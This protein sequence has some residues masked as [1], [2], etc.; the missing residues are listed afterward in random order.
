MRC[1]YLDPPDPVRCDRAVCHIFRLSTYL[2]YLLAFFSAKM[3]GR[4]GTYRIMAAIAVHHTAPTPAL[5][6]AKRNPSNFT[7]PV[8]PCT[9]KYCS[10]NQRYCFK[11][12]RV[13]APPV[14]QEI[15]VNV[16]FAGKLC[17]ADARLHRLLHHGDFEVTGEIRPT[18]PLTGD[19]NFT[20]GPGQEERTI[21]G[22]PDGKVVCP[23]F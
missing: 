5:Q 10:F 14:E 19:R 16:I 9:T 8:L 20:G 21:F 11:P 4:R 6:G 15:V 12:L 17:H 22:S 18:G 13:K 7:G 1:K 3:V 23:D 2:D